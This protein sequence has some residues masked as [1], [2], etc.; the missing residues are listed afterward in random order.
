MSELSIE[1]LEVKIG[2][3]FGAMSAYLGFDE[4]HWQVVALIR[5][6]EVTE[7]WIKGKVNCLHNKAIHFYDSKEKCNDFIRSLIKEIQG[8]A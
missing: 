4:A 3:A 1:E 2:Y 7:R 5:K 6:P 8:V